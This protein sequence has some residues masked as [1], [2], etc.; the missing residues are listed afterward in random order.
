MITI[1]ITILIIITSII[2]SIWAWNDASIMNELIFIPKYTRFNNR[3][4][5]FITSGFIHA[6]WM[7][8]FFNM[9]TLYFFGVYVEQSFNLNFDV[10]L[11]RTLFLLF[12]FSSLIISIL[13]TYFE[14]KNNEYYR[15]LG[16]SGAV[17]AIVFAGILLNP[18]MKI[19]IFILPPIIPGYI[20]APVYLLLTMYLSKNKESG[21]NHSAHLWGSLYGIIFVFTI[22][23]FF[24]KV[25]IFVYF[26]KM[27]LN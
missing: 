1:N 22:F 13:P 5:T 24:L 8:L 19:G 27:I 18:T 9:L 3:V 6:D 11:G 23:Y 2:I 21:I 7:H 15:C 12:Y 14:N 10:Q 4:F 16:A 26:L 25:N 17:S 20:F